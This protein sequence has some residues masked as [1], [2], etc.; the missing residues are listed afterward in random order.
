MAFLAFRLNRARKNKW[1]GYFRKRRR[2]KRSERHP[3]MTKPTHGFRS[4]C[5]E[6][7][8]NSTKVGMYDGTP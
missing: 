3:W 7:G 8:N 2:E 6:M 4:R 5:P 1:L